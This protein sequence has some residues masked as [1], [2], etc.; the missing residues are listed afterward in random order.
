VTLRKGLQYDYALLHIFQYATGPVD[1]RCGE[2]SSKSFD[3]PLPEVPF[4]FNRSNAFQVG[5]IGTRGRLG[6]LGYE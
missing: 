3:P 2:N 1:M 5:S 6:E 4:R